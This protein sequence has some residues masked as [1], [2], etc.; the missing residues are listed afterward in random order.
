M[1]SY[2][3]PALRLMSSIYQA[4][5]TI[6]EPTGES[7]TP[8]KFT[9]GLLL[10]VNFDAELENIEDLKNVRIKVRSFASIFLHKALLVTRISFL[11]I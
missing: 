8:L 4:K 7:D 2:H 9:A 10:G 6:Y 11:K 5:A 3:C 1:Q